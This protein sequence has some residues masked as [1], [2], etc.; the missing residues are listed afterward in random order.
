MGIVVHSLGDGGLSLAEEAGIVQV[1]CIG[2]YSIVVAKILGLGHLF[3]VQQ[4]LIELLSV[5]RTDDPNLV[6]RIQ[7]PKQ[8]LR[9]SADRRRRSLL[10][11]NVSRFAMS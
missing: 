1:P 9:Q 2:R 10:D 3:A 8:G 4:R 11:K 7:E 6:L 5:A